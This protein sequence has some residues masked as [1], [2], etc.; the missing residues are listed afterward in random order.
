MAHSDLLHFDKKLCQKRITV[1]V[2]EN[3][4]NVKIQKLPSA[5]VLKLSL[6]L[7]FILK[8]IETKIQ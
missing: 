8:Q 7:L 2:F 6:T 1:S 4:S 3:I 5:N